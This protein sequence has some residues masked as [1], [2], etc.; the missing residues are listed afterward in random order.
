MYYKENIACT[1]GCGTNQV[2]AT[3][4]GNENYLGMTIAEFSGVKTSGSLDKS[5]CQTQTGTTTPNSTSV[6]TSNNGQLI[7]GFT[8]DSSTGSVTITKEASAT[9]LHMAGTTDGTGSQYEVQ[10]SAGAITSNFTF[11]ASRTAQTEIATFRDPTVVQP[12]KHKVISD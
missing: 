7:V 3:W 1:G 9:N 8:I 11:S 4:A 2:T 5:A 10:S 12:I 6:T